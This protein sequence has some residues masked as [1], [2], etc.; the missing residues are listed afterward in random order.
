MPTPDP[1]SDSD[2]LEFDAEV[3]A[4]LIGKYVLI[5]VTFKDK[6]GN[7]KRKEQFHGIVAAV[8]PRRGISVSLRG[9]GSGKTKTLP[10]ATAP[11]APAPSGT[12]RLRSTGESIVNPDFTALWVVSEPDA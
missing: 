10:P 11:F 3:A 1:P 4:S 12:Y 6:L 2:R 8:D 5:G 9:E 7:L